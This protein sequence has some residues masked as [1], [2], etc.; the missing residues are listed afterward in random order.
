MKWVFLAVAVGAC[1]GSSPTGATATAPLSM[2]GGASADSEVD[3]HTM[4]VDEA[5]PSDGAL[6]MPDRIVPVGPDGAPATDANGHV[7]PVTIESLQV[8]GTHNSYHI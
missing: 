6:A 3:N 2:D 7:G 8:A 4:H 5:Q 1:R